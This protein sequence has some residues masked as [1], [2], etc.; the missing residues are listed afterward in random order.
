M[1]LTRDFK[2]TVKARAV[3]DAAFREALLTD[4]VELLIAGEVEVGKAVLRDYININAT[5][6]FEKLAK[7]TGTPSKSLMRMFGPKGNPRA[8]NLFA[9]IGKLQRVSG[10]RLAVG[11][12]R[13]RAA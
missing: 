10:V 2:E 12:S 11:S 6:G 13:K 3:R 1:V 5:V 9:L 8:N 4:A 7:A